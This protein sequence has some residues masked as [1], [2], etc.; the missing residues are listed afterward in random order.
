MPSQLATAP[1]L[2]A[3]GI[4]DELTSF[5]QL[6][7]RISA[8]GAENTKILGDAFEIFVE[9]YL[10]TQQ[11]LQV[12]ENWIVGQVPPA[13]RQEMNLPNDSKGIDGI[14]R[15]RTGALVP[16][17]VKFRSKRA[18]LT[19]TEVSSFLGL[20]ER[21]QDRLLIT[22]S[23]EVA[24]DAKNRDGM[25]TVR[26]ID[27]DDLTADDFK[28]IE[29]WLKQ[30][31]V[32]APPLV[33]R[34]YQVEAL[35]G[36]ARTLADADRAH[37]VMA[38]GTGKTLV[39]LWAVEDL[40]PQT[41]LVL[42]PSL[43]LLQQTLNEWS[44]HTSW[45]DRFSHLCIC[46]DAT[47]A[48]RDGEDAVHLDAMDVDFKVGTDP[49]EVRRFI[50]QPTDRVKVVFSTY[51]SSRVVSK[52]MAGLPAFDIALFDEA[53]KTTGAKGTLFA[54]A[55]SDENLA[56][57]KRLF[58][59]ATPRQYD[60][61]HRDA[62]GDF[63]FIS[64]D[65]EAI[66]GPRAYTLTFGRAATEK[67]ICDYKVVISIVD[68]AEVNG[69]A[70][71]HGITLVDGDQIGTKWVASQLAVERAIAETGA[72]RAISFHSRVSNAAAFSSE[73]SRGV[74]Q[75]LDGFS[76]FHVNGKQSSSDRKQLIKAFR[77]AP[78][79]LVTNARCLTE[80]VDVPAVDMVV[81]VDPRQ[82]RVD[83]AQATGRAM[84]RSGADKAHGYVV[85]PLFLE[86]AADESLEAAFER[87]D[88]K[89][90]AT[91]LN[92]MQ[93]QD[94]DL[95]DIIRQLKEAKGR[96]D[97]FNPK[98][99][100]NKVQ[101]IG[102]PVE[103]AALTRSVQV[104][105]VDWLGKGWDQWFGLLQAFHAREGHC[106]VPA[107]YSVDGYKLGSWIVHQ[108]HSRDTFTEERRRRLDELGFSW[109]PF[110]D[111][112]EEGFS[113]LQ[114]FQA[115]EGHSRVPQGYTEDGYKLGTW[116]ANQRKK[117][118]SLTGE[119]CRRLD[120]LGFN[121]D[122]H[123]EK[124][125]EGF[126]YLQT[127]H[128]REGHSRVPNNYSENDFKVGKWVGKQRQ[129][130]DSLTEDR[131]RRLDELGFVWNE[132][133]ER[134]EAGFS[135]LKMFHSHEGHCQVPALY[136]VDGYTLGSWVS[137]Q[138]LNHKELTEERRRRLDELGFNWDPFTERWEQGF[139]HLQIFHAREGHSRVPR[140]YSEDGFNLSG[141][142]QNQRTELVRLTEN[143]RQRLDELGFVWDVW[144]EQWGIGFS[145]LQTFY[146]REGHIL[147]PKKH[148]EDGFKLGGWVS[149]QKTRYAELS[150]DRRH[151]LDELGFVWGGR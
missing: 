69:F 74:G 53:H 149:N 49:S 48:Q 3:R 86:R 104:E 23:N 43:T 96:G 143:R 32:Q 14:F 100:M 151:R 112:W 21:A 58:L 13:I 8:L 63:K 11:K 145:Y 78:K 15:A 39:A 20:T 107:L 105:I 99:L 56:C 72:K 138:R 119:L 116:A 129:K 16:Y 59:T 9:A 22:N 68:G 62:E 40:S 92:A 55:L 97:I 35:E 88:F 91:V 47:V 44:K 18:Y 131:R 94:E 28:V 102:P 65:D 77:N 141:W 114:A 140:G 31:P 34:P 46:S 51:Q 150:E 136:S 82:S 61:N 12:E 90:V 60:I 89:A 148:L 73:G 64:M 37:V 80:G 79:A 71:D 122:P 128:A 118:D 124:W 123:V 133:S 25:R 10:A 134:W 98:N 111:Q 27:F 5:A 84:R 83:I 121:W 85:V 29:G 2:I 125:E 70:L 38:C 30:T 76:L 117:R 137:V 147:V 75:F 45:G 142:V 57:R 33:R 135:H 139:S 4:F 93:E 50:E 67:I 54:H 41:V 66:Y 109:D 115:R 17:Q 103:L 24:L 52:G 101:V 132:I 19:Y 7:D 113:Y 130:R 106:R 144:A 87:S 95:V 1:A 36:I 127:F 126:S 6:E 26:G 120:E 42:L 81:F 108:R 110:T 146:A